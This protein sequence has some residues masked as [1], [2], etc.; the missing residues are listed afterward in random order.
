MGLVM[1][2][3][4]WLR[5]LCSF[6]M[7]GQLSAGARVC[8]LLSRAL[9]H[10]QCSA[11]Q[12]GNRGLRARSRC[13]KADNQPLHH[14]SYSQ[15]LP[16]SQREAHEHFRS[17]MVTPARFPVTSSALP[18]QEMVPSAPHLCP[19]CEVPLEAL[20]WQPLSGLS[21]SSLHTHNLLLSKAFR[22]T[23]K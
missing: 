2:W 10:T 12:S 18:C 21:V 3:Q 4:C 22:S 6:C 17:H 15:L 9:Q 19:R 8:S 13:Q 14:P 16:R 11:H 1:C 23:F 20:P 7:R 5:S